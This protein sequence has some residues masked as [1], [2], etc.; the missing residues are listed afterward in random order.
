M[1]ERLQRLYAELNARGPRL[2]PGD[3]AA[4][5]SFTAYPVTLI[6]KFVFTSHFKRRP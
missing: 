1:E 6:S 4:Q 2:R 3:E 5:L